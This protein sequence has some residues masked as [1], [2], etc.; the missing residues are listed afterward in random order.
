[1]YIVGVRSGTEN[2]VINHPGGG[3]PTRAPCLSWACTGN[4]ITFGYII[5][6]NIVFGGNIIILLNV[7]G[8]GGTACLTNKKK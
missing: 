3:F 7:Y 8:K 6:Y 4:N 5:L 1:M 2:R